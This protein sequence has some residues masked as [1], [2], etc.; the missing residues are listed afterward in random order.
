MIGFQE[1]N[2]TTASTYNYYPARS[3]K[4]D[5]YFVIDMQ[6]ETKD[7]VVT[8]TTKTKTG[9]GDRTKRTWFCT[10]TAMRGKKGGLTIR[11]MGDQQKFQETLV[12]LVQEFMLKVRANAVSMR[13]QKKGSGKIFDMRVKTLFRK[14]RYGCETTKILNVGDAEMAEDYSFFVINKPGYNTDKLLESTDT[15]NQIAAKMTKEIDISTKKAIIVTADMVPGFEEFH[16]VVKAEWIEETPSRRVTND[17]MI[18]PS[19][20]PVNARVYR[21][22][23]EDEATSLTSPEAAALARV[24]L[25]TID[26][27]IDLMTI[28]KRL[29]PA[30]D[31]V[32]E[33]HEA[34]VKRV[35]TAALQVKSR[36]YENV[37]NRLAVQLQQTPAW[38]DVT[39]E[40]QGSVARY[41]GA[42][43]WNV[44]QHLL[45][46]K[47]D[48]K[49]HK[50]ITDI[51]EAFEQAGVIAHNI[52]PAPTLYRGLEMRGSDVSSILQT[53]LFATTAFMSTSIDPLIAIEFAECSSHKLLFKGRTDNK[54]VMAD[55]IIE[56]AKMS[57][58][59]IIEPDGLPVYIPGRNGQM[60][61]NEF[62]VN[63]NTVF[64]ADV[65]QMDEDATHAIIRLSVRDSGAY[66]ESIVGVQ[67][68][69]ERLQELESLATV[70]LAGNNKMPE[71]SRVKFSK[72]LKP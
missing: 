47:G 21:Q 7:V 61:E 42:Q 22:R 62:I 56:G 65:I 70:L 25:G 38:A 69:Q 46:G 57:V 12:K 64:D 2:E 52:Q 32:P 48:E 16:D 28:A 1:L 3:T 30:I 66:S 44:N 31:A 35:I 8:F 9:L 23:L 27:P 51:D 45:T 60:G 37:Y 54:Q 5:R 33:K 24:A 63:R 6:G 18:L 68:K 40:V 71:S 36:E 14:L 10:V 50:I 53:G 67:Q 15:I 19:N 49:T 72:S 4:V 58:V 55:A 11:D 34:A 59:F 29:A 17:P 41:T 26:L 39:P 20:E 43:Y 13:V